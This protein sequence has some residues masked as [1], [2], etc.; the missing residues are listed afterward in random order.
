MFKDEL[1]QDQR[2]SII[3][4]CSEIQSVFPL[5]CFLIISP[6]LEILNILLEH[7][8]REQREASLGHLTSSDSPFKL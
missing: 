5:I 7:C 3:F 2:R 1:K 4:K 8:L 6:N